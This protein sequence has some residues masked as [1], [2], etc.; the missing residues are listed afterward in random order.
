LVLL[1]QQELNDWVI[2]ACDCPSD[3]WKS[4]LITLLIPW[5]LQLRV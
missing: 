5:P 1:H 4:R 2:R 3:W